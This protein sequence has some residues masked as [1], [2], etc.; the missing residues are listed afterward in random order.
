MYN[1]IDE[2]GWCLLA[3]L[4]RDNNTLKWLNLAGTMGGDKGCKALGDS[5]KVNKTLRVLNLCTSLTTIFS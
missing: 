2:K 1:N 4:L 3:D 5:L